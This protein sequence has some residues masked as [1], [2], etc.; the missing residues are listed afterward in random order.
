MHHWGHARVFI[1]TC[2]YLYT[3]IMLLTLI[4]LPSIS[5]VR[6]V[7]STPMVFCWFS[8]NIPDLKLWTTQVL[9]TSES[10]TRM[11]LNRKSKLSSWSGSV[12]CIVGRDAQKKTPRLKCRDQAFSGLK[13]KINKN[14]FYL[15][16]VN[17]KYDYVNKPQSHHIHRQCL[18]NNIQTF[19]IVGVEAT[20]FEVESKPANVT[21]YSE[22]ASVDTEMHTNIKYKNHKRK[23]KLLCPVCRGLAL[24][25]V[26]WQ[27]SRCP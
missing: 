7:K 11:I 9:P 24:V 8:A 16:C 26:P 10:P 15:C 22:Y 12:D 2:A 21:I 6:T 1:Y 23:P 25:N 4:L 19:P 18:N 3:H 17:T 20:P 14:W 5:R 27:R 13:Q